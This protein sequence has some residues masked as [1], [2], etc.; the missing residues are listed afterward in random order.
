M[1]VI[2]ESPHFIVNPSLEVYVRKKINKL[3]HFNNRLL[4]AR[5]I[6]KLDK[7]DTE[8]N[9]VCELTLVAPRK[10]LFAIHNA[11]TFEDAIIESVR[12]IESQLKKQKTSYT[13]N[14]E[15]INVG[16][17]GSEETGT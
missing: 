5:V 3:N 11:I 1:E 6:L 15:K 10:N 14:K 2:V 7:S 4:R 17:V 9:K 8:C 16:D 12:S 13:P